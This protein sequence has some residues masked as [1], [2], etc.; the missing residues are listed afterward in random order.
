MIVFDAGVL[1]GFLDSR[2]VFHEAAVAF[3]EENEGADF[4]VTAVTLA[5]S[6]VRPSAKGRAQFLKDGLARMQMSTIDIADRDVLGIAEVRATTRL[7]MPDALVLHCA[8]VRN[9]QIVTTDTTLASV[10]R[11]RGVQAH[12]LS[13]L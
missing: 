3:I 9:A 10:A 11:D 8:G 7:R 13:P 4:A 2:D 1:I 12:L 6:L 5:E